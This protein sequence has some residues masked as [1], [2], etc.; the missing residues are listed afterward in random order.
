MA[1]DIVNGIRTSLAIDDNK[2]ENE[3]SLH[4]LYSSLD[5]SSS[6]YYSET[7]RDCDIDNASLRA[8]CCT[9][10][11]VIEGWDE[12]LQT[13]RSFGIKDNSV[14]CDHMIH[15]LYGKVKDDSSNVIDLYKLYNKLGPLLEKKCLDKNTPEKSFKIFVK[16]HN[17]KILKDKKELYDFLEYFDNV[18]RILNRIYNKKKDKYCTYLKYILSLYTEMKLNNF[19]KMYDKEI[20]YFEQKFKEVFTELPLLEKNCPGDYLNLVFDKENNTLRELKHEK[21]KESLKKTAVEY[22]DT[23]IA[24]TDKTSH[25]MSAYED[26][27][28]EFSSSKIYEKLNS[29]VDIKEYY[30]TC[31]DILKLEKLFP[32]SVYLCEKLSRNIR[33]SI[34]Y[35]SSNEE[36]DHDRCLY[37]IFWTY[38]EI[39]KIYNGKIRKIFETPLFVELVKVANNI[40]YELSG[41]DVRINS[42]LIQNEFRN[43]AELVRNLLSKDPKIN[44]NIPN[45]NEVM[46][47]RFV[48]KNELFKYK[49]CFYSFDCGFDE[50]TEMKDLFDYFKNYDSMETKA[51]IL[52]NKRML[53]CKYIMYINILYEKYISKCCTCFFRSEKCIDDCPDY[54]KCNQLYNPYN[55]YTT[56]KCN[57]VLYQVTPMKKVDIPKYID[58]YVIIKSEKSAEIFTPIGSIFHKKTPQKKKEKYNYHEKYNELLLYPDLESVN[59]NPQSRKIQIAYYRT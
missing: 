19:Q 3:N 57:A 53:F 49:P 51:S 10:E 42:E 50:C 18:K 59:M 52:T 35:I 37:F 40:Y 14:C 54:F 25:G 55:L 1:Q 9:I 56:L 23:E 13:F 17:K 46:K 41:N 27:L 47:E 11:K 48:R 16:T 2:F 5:A 22:K 15:W 29:N 31:K 45:K 38:D 6:S 21:G 58:R 8:I 4:R 30:S 43:K 44:K 33:N 39:K 20:E 12:Y 24:L 36:N 7:C 26:I 34:S 32:G 28:K